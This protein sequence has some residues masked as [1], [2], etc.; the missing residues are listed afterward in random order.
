[1][2]DLATNAAISLHEITKRFPGG[3]VANDR[4][5]CAV[6]PGE[7][8]GLLGENG[9]GKT[10]LMK[11]LAG[12]Y[13][14]DSGEVRVNGRVVSFRSPRDAK[15]AGIAMVHQHF[16]LVPAFTVAENLALSDTSGGLILHPDR[17]RQHLRREAERLGLDVRLDA[18]VWELS[19][20]EK[21]RVEVFRL[22]LEGAHVLILDEPTSILAP[23]EAEH[24]LE[25]LKNFKEFGHA[26]FL[27]THKIEQVV[28][29][30]D[31]ITV[32]RGG[33]VVGTLPAR[34]AT[35]EELA[36]MMV[37]RHVPVGQNGMRVFRPHDSDR[38]L[39]DVSH[40]NVKPVASAYG[41]S[42]VS[43]TV[44]AGEVLG[45]AGVSGNGQ[46]ELA[47]A[48][49]G[50]TRY[51]GVV[52]VAG[53]EVH[54]A[55]GVASLG[56]VPG[57]RLGMGVAPTLTVLDN[58][59]LKAFHSDGFSR[60][61][62]LHKARLRRT[63]QGLIERFGIS[64]AD[65]DVTVRSLSGGNV[66]KILLARELSREPEV[67]V[68]VTPTAGLDIATVEYVHTQL[69]E[70]ASRGHGIILISEDLDELL[71]LCDRIIVLFEGR[72]V[73][74]FDHERFDSRAIGLLM[75]GVGTTA[76]EG[77]ADV[78]PAPATA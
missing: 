5:S 52:H 30:A 55:V 57:D 47:A 12:F 71:L 33:S 53:N 23:R 37:G 51:H 64:P 22:L 42:D 78:G 62:W 19:M 9:A 35:K 6:L 20:G 14:P 40:L 43:F 41:L 4:V 15:D 50:L 27:V 13:R 59:S 11:V 76:G 61:P 63:A 75:S 72:A 31:R 16:S 45:I 7:I 36:E 66:Q 65:P 34:E 73:G 48:L 10:T 8:H 25:H 67:L 32:L 70:M 60:G 26:I 77:A 17:W 46:D 54:P 21:Q 44:H 28:A 1:M 24:L 38:V 2:N 18:F 49:S 74:S 29:F 68:A 56:Y 58:L 69:V 3:V 39:L